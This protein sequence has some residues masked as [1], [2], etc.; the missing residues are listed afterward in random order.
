MGSAFLKDF[1][2]ASQ[3]YRWMRN[4]F[5]L[6]PPASIHDFIS[7]TSLLRHLG[8]TTILPFNIGILFFPLSFLWANDDSTTTTNKVILHVYVDVQSL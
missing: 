1:P 8:H 3:R 5:G 2:H 6:I 7:V 4:L